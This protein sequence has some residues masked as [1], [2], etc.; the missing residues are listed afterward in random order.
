LTVP[1]EKLG[2]KLLKHL[3]NNPLK[4]IDKKKLLFFG[5][6]VPPKG[7]AFELE[8]TP[9]INPELEEERERMLRALK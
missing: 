4:Q 5:D 2:N 6:G 8:K 7:L 1:S 3:R 9:Y